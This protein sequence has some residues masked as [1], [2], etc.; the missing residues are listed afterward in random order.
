MSA[1]ALIGDQLIL[2]E[3]YDENYAPSEQEI[4]EYAREIGIDPD[5]EPEL[6]WL[7]R[8][9]IVAPL[10]PEWKPCQDVTGEIYYFNFS[11]G[12]ST[13]DHP[14]DE[15]YRRLVVQEREHVQLTATAG[16]AWVKKDK[17]KKKKKTEKK[18]NK[19]KKRKPSV[20]APGGLTSVFPSPLVSLAP[21]QSPGPLSGNAPALRG[22]LSS[23][24][25][26]EPL[27]STLG[28]F[29]KSGAS[30]VLGSRQ[31]LGSL[32]LPGFDDDDDDD[33]VS[34]E[35]ESG[36][37]DPSRLLKN[38]L[39]DQNALGGGLQYED[40]EASGKAAQ[41]ERTEP[42][43]QDLALSGDHSPE[44][45]SQ[46]DSL[47]GHHLHL[48]PRLLR[49]YPEHSAEHSKRDVA[50]DFS[51]VEDGGVKGE[52]GSFEE[53]VVE[54]GDKGEEGEEG[55]RSG[56]KEVDEPEEGQERSKA[57]IERENDDEEEEEVWVEEV[58]K[59]C[60]EG[61]NEEKEEWDD[62]VTENKPSE[63]Q[64]EDDSHDKVERCFERHKY[65]ECVK[66]VE[67]VE[68][69]KEGMQGGLEH[70]QDG[71][72]DVEKCFKSDKDDKTI[73][74]LSGSM[75]DEESEE[76]KGEV[77]SIG[78]QEKEMDKEEEEEDDGES[79]EV[80]E[81]CSL[82]Q[83]NL[84]ESEKDV[85]ER[86]VL[87]EGGEG[88]EGGEA[89]G[90]GSESQK[91]PAALER[92][93]EV[94]QVFKMEAAQDRRA[95]LGQK[96]MLRDLKRC[97]DKSKIQRKNMTEKC[98]A[99][100]ESDTSKHIQTSAS[101]DVKVS[102]HFLDVNNLSAAEPEESEEEVKTKTGSRY[103]HAEE[104]GH[105]PKVDRHRSSPPPSSCPSSCPSPSEQS[106]E[107]QPRSSLEFQRPK[108]GRG[109][110]VCSV[111]TEPEA[112]ELASQNP[113]KHSWRIP[114]EKDSVKKEARTK[115]EREERSLRE[116]EDE[117]EK[118]EKEMTT[119]LLEEKLKRAEE[120]E[121]EEERK[122]KEESEKILRALRERLLCKRRE[123][124]ARVTEE[125][126]RTLEKL[127]ESVQEETQK[128]KHKL[129]LESVA[130]LKEFCVTLED[131]RSAERD[132]LIAQKKQDIER[133][134]AELDEE[135]QGE[136]R[137]LLQEQGEEVN[138]LKQEVKSSERKR[139]LTVS[140][141]PEQHLADYHRDL[142]DLLQ[143]VREEVQRD[144]E[145]KLEELRKE[146]LREIN[147]IR[148]NYLNK[149]SELQALADQLEL[150]A[151]ELK[152]LEAMLQNKVADLN[153]R[154]KMFGEKEEEAVPRLIQ[155]RD[156]LREELERTRTEK[157]HAQESA[158]RAREERSKAKEVEE[159]LREERN[160]ARDESRRAKDEQEKLQREVHLLQEKHHSLS[161]RLSELEHE[162]GSVSLTREPQ[163]DKVR[164]DKPAAP[165]PSTDKRGGLADP[166]VPSGPDS[167]SMDDSSSGASIHKT[168]VFKERKS[169]QLLETQTSSSQ[170]LNHEGSVTE[171]ILHFLQ[172]ARNVS[173]LERIVQ[174]GN[175]LLRRTEE[176]LQQLDIS[177][178]EEP[179]SEDLSPLRKVTFDV[180]D[181]D[182]SSS[183]DP[184]IKTKGHSAVPAK[185]QQL[186]ESLQQISGQ[187]NTVLSALGSI[188]QR[189]QSST[190]RTAF[191]LHQ[192]DSASSSKPV[193]PHMPT[194]CH[195]SISAPPFRKLSEHSGKWVP[196]E[197]LYSASEDLVNR[198]WSQMF[199]GAAMNPVTSST[200][201][202]TS[203]YSSYTPYSEHRP[204]L[205][206]V[207]Q[208]VEV[209]GERLQRE[210]DSKKRWLQRRMKDTSIPLLTRCHPPSSKSGLV[211]LGLDDNNQIR[212]YHY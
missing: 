188:S 74:E 28:D 135:L 50:E 202:S 201:I 14:C 197:S 173:E 154:K 121:Q 100:E 71:N 45:L 33:D 130:M 141:R 203:A 23:S 122:L 105:L 44:P 29:R 70:E 64:E 209:D 123:E 35:K 147:N 87:S 26:L 145:R 195:H 206:L 139:A 136:R 186:A 85:S 69:E 151:E 152:S 140:P 43:L 198:R 4:Q 16:G 49:P 175:T 176:H 22:S 94:N 159:R 190:P 17:K 129:R 102:E 210:I 97:D 5:R 164:G 2:E 112:A 120:E 66:A 72:T 47:R 95:K 67:R 185:V 91:L 73:D 93:K 8:E 108:T 109:R 114:K 46:Q 133:L 132:R 194:V 182:L 124:E 19:E 79:E 211:Q 37:Q 89:E 116:K 178:A 84:T 212:V 192:P 189:Q 81:R 18:E 199:P 143:G 92:E 25:G 86:C 12:Q 101:F 59:E 54:E 80:L 34:S 27:K 3:D 118:R 40:S 75:H 174:K 170:D 166:P 149:E 183:A 155:E 191:S 161:C 7:A 125:S 148:E 56:R 62:R 10:P 55:N 77:S 150:R 193:L 196:Q 61:E 31:K 181:S 39:L 9:G 24:G 142:A 36:P 168:K 48:S 106:V 6:L 21:L 15:H 165:G 138:S 11:S 171:E 158:Q 146:H 179:L 13:W 82:S 104:K 115:T 110:R 42:E 78:E 1:A 119:H 184:H 204:G 60:C 96:I 20:N 157:H 134:R 88:G 58:E 76:E 57:T 107:L 53:G 83:R 30:S 65:K 156:Q 207:T 38:L 90:E 172:E 153:K 128:Q 208:S 180:L 167:Q 163:S 113:D 32:T 98:Q 68:E 127:R 205:Q 169:N 111:I 63:K 117:K 162:E 51:E 103:V 52:G 144:H 177:I 200:T 126:E 160:K 99:E 137:R 187:L 41:E 131:E